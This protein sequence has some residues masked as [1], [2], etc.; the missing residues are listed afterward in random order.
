MRDW[1]EHW[2]QR[3]LLNATMSTC[4]RRSVGAVAVRDR[5]SFADAFNGN[6]PGEPHCDE[7]GCARCADTGT[8]AGVGLADCTCVHA[9]ANLVTFCASQGIRM[10]GATV[11]C[12][13]HPCADCIKLLVSAGV[14]EVVYEEPY[15]VPQWAYEL[16]RMTI[17]SFHG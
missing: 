2:R 15:P 10:E 8:M 3:A 9:E 11:Y 4:M 16:R 12:T 5:R 13:T 6:M 1:D 17:R 7:G 14:A